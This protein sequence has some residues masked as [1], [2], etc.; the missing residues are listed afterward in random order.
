MPGMHGR[1]VTARVKQDPLLSHTPVV[2][3]TATVSNEITHGSEAFIDRY[4][5]PA[6]LLQVRA[7]IL[8]AECGNGDGTCRRGQRLFG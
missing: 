2:F 6:V 4:D 7:Y 1:E 8:D 5:Y 3:L